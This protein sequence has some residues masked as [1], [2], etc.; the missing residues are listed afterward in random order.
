MIYFIENKNSEA[1]KIGYTGNDINK[2]LSELQIA[3]PEELKLIGVMDGE[4]KEEKKL[5]LKFNEL[6]IRGEW[7][8][9]TKELNNFILENIKISFKNEIGSGINLK[10]IMDKIE[11]RYIKQAL[12]ATKGNKAKAA[13]LL[14]IT[15]RSI[16]YRIERL[17]I[18]Q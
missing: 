13:K 5:H 8:K 12:R 2:R 15:P 17:Q 16:R 6:L 1:I 7:F 9:S 11:N 10:K 4:I 18:G 14:N 3:T